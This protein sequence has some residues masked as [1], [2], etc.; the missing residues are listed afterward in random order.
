MSGILAAAWRSFTASP[1]SQVHVEVDLRDGGRQGAL[2]ELE[3]EP[4]PFGHGACGMDESFEDGAFAAGLSGG[5][6]A[7]VARDLLEG[8]GR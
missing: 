5:R 6:V 1:V 4:D 8:R 7:G 3:D 2:E